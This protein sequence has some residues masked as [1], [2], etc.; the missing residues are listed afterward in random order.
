MAKAVSYC[1]RFL[2]C[3]RH[4]SRI[5]SQLHTYFYPTMAQLQ[6]QKTPSGSMLANHFPLRHD[7]EHLEEHHGE[8]RVTVRPFSGRFTTFTKVVILL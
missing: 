8:N 4:I 1:H 7:I 5:S 3:L 2:A 6:H